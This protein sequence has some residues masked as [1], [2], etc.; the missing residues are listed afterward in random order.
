MR[1]VHVPSGTGHGCAL[2]APVLVDLNVGVDA[3]DAVV[4]ARK[5]AIREDR[6]DGGLIK[7]VAADASDGE[8]GA[9][10]TMRGGGRQNLARSTIVAGQNAHRPW[11]GFSCQTQP[12]FRVRNAARENQIDRRREE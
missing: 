1:A 2:K 10:A 11:S 7:N 6:A 9:F 8:R 5:L 4:A 3:A 12:E